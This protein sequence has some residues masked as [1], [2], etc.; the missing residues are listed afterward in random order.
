MQDFA[1]LTQSL[2]K[3]KNP[4]YFGVIRSKVRPT[5][6]KGAELLGAVDGC[7]VCINFPATFKFSPATSKSIDIPGLNGSLCLVKLKYNHYNYISS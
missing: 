4:I 1:P 3:G 6:V 5:A 2:W 7:T